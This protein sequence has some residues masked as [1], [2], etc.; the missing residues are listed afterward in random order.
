VTAVEVAAP[1]PEFAISGVEAEPNAATPLLRFAVSVTDASGRDVYTIAAAAQ[2]QID[3]DR[4]AYDPETR[5]RLLDLFGE[6]ARIP[7]TAGSLQLGRVDTLVPSFNGNGTFTIALPVSADL[8]LAA[9]RYMASLPGGTV[10]L[11][12]N[13]N[14]TIFY[15]G[16]NDRLR[17]TLVPWSCSARYRLSVATWRAMIERR[18]AGSGFVR[19]QPDT[20][21]RLRL[22]R[23]E[24]GLPTLEATIGALLAEST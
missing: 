24:R 6:A 5:R 8:E 17:M 11:T 9:G 18:Y 4:R 14:G 3:A 10:P 7:A 16:E 13:F 1:S 15:G 21:E 19:L 2:I 12:F 20:L 22:R 23:A